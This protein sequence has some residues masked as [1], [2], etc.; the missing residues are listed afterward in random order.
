MVTS[1]P[2]IEPRLSPHLRGH[3]LQFDRPSLV[4]LAASIGTRLLLT[5]ILLEVMR[6]LAVKWLGAHV[7]LWILLPL[8]LLVALLAVP[9]VTG[10]KPS[11]IGLRPLRHW[12]TT[13]KSYFLQVLVLA[14]VVF[15]LV[16]G[17]RL[18]ERL[19]ESGAVAT[20]LGVFLPYLCFGFYQEIVYRG[21]LQ[22]AIVRRWG[23]F[24]GILVANVLYTFGPL[25][26][27]Y[28]A[29]PLSKSAPMFGAI[30]AIGLFFGLVYHRSGNL[31]MVAVFHAIGNA[32]IVTSLAP[33][34]PAAG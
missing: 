10:L 26:S 1:E 33:M 24:A 15:P 22:T 17:A 32:Y 8:M 34:R 13:E 30:F 25:H 18:R 19:A 9:V 6:L 2:T 29:Y 3:L 7:P 23:A 31:W 16:L 14:N 4:Q 11:D 5:A 21:L 12:T 27:Q 28:F 20:L